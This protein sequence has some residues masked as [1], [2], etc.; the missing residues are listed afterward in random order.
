MND[1]ERVGTGG[2]HNT[3]N[4]CTHMSEEMNSLY[5]SR[6]FTFVASIAA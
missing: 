3:N 6:L 2:D 1:D 5:N 4:L